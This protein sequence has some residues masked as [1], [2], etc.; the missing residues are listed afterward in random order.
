M[1][2]L[3]IICAAAMLG[4][5]CRSAVA[6]SLGGPPPDG[7]ADSYQVEGLGYLFDGD[8]AT[9]KN[10]GEEYRRNVPI[11]YYT[12]DANFL[13]YFGSN[14]IHAVDSAMG[15]FN[16]LT[17]VSRYSADLS[18]F[19]LNSQEVNFRAE[20]LSL[21]D[22][23][24][25]TMGHMTEQL[26]LHSPVRWVWALRA[27]DEIDGCP[28]FVQY[29][30]IK[31]N[32]DPVPSLLSDFQMSSYVNGILYSYFI[33]EDCG[34]GD[35]PDSDAIEFPVDPLSSQYTAVADYVS[36]LYFGLGAGGYY[37]GLT[38]DDVGGLRY[39]LRTNNINLESSGLTTVQFVTNFN[40]NLLI[41]TLD[42]GVFLQQA[43][44]NSAAVLVTLYPGLVITSTTN[45]FVNV[46]TTNITASF[47]N[48]P[49]APATAPASIVFTTNRITNVLEVFV[50]TFANV[51]TN[52]VFTHAIVTTETISFNSSPYAPWPSFTLTTN[53]THRLIQQPGGDFFILP[54][55][56]CAA[57]IVRSQLTTV[58]PTITP[59]IIGTNTGGATN[60]GPFVQT[61]VTY[62]TN[63]QLVYH[64]VTCPADTVSSRQGIDRIRFVRRDFDSLLGQFFYPITNTYTLI[65]LTNNRLVSQRIERV[66]T[67]P[68][69]LFTAEDTMGDDQA[70][71]G[72]LLSRRSINYDTT[73][74]PV[75]LAGPGT[76]E[77]PT[78]IT[79]NKGA[80]VWGNGVIGILLTNVTGNENTQFPLWIWGSFDG[81]TNPPVVY[82][83]GTSITNLENMLLMSVF[84]T[85]L[86]DGQVGAGY[87]TSFSGTGGQPPYT[88]AFAG[89]SPGL[90]GGLS[91]SPGGQVSGIPV[92]AGTYD[93]VIQMTDTTS[94]FVEV[95]ITI[96]INP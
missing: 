86:P 67:Q 45:D 50:H 31:R 59:I 1:R 25:Y 27:R 54:P 6:F 74:R 57:D 20:A 76:I 70:D 84:P 77:I 30:V 64:A 85:T 47:T 24:S 44:T 14:G 69:F 18:E 15:V 12:M 4:L 91:L 87:N 7:D 29:F 61:T 96:T 88:W 3:K 75:G 46:V 41:S 71:D 94:R 11:L 73:A 49:T 81:S 55:G 63:H 33:Y 66:V 17:N 5:L 79:L 72:S 9:P 92:S 35:L 89:N 2:L 23:K 48:F 90:P 60:V 80:P 53:R 13:N 58:I 37:T 26:G 95:P 21:R 39:L 43:R 93:F 82:P 62:F 83:N 65:E 22:L 68:D 56:L 34:D 78:T 52:E 36:P 19:P 32:Y 28:D 40:A 10:I 38:R 8:I 42:F 51:V 16:N